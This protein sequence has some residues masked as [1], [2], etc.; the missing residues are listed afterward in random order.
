M[1]YGQTPDILMLHWT[2]GTPMCAF[3]VFVCACVR[4]GVRACVRACLCFCEARL[5][6]S[7]VF[8]GAVEIV[9]HRVC[10]EFMC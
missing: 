10:V 5:Q 8:C 7:C 9:S 3:V 6:C 2:Y 1:L 4:V